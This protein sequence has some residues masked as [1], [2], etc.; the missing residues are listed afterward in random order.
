MPRTMDLTTRAEIRTRLEGDDYR[1][2]PILDRRC[3]AVRRLS[4]ND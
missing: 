2:R 4:M 3:L 1:E